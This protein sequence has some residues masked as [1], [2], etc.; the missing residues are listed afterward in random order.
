MRE[1]IINDRNELNDK[2][3]GVGIQCWCKVMRCAT[4]CAAFARVGM[5]KQDRSQDIVAI[6][7]AVPQQIPIGVLE[8][9]TIVPA[10]L[11]LVKG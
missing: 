9:G 8:V 7:S 1:L 5:M 6:C 2:A 11:G 3:T 4:D 10:G